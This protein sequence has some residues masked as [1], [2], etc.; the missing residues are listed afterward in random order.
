MRW[1]V[2]KFLVL[3]RLSVKLAVF[4]LAIK[5]KYVLTK[6][7][8]FCISVIILV[9]TGELTRHMLIE[10]HELGMGNGDYAF[11]GVELIKQSGSAG[12]FSWYKPGDRRNKV[13]REMYESLMM[14]AVRVPT[15]PEYTSFVHKVTKISSEEF[16]G[17]ANHENASGPVARIHLPDD[18]NKSAILFAGQSDC[19]CLLR[20]CHDV[21]TCLQLHSCCGWRCPWRSLHGAPSLEHVLS[22]W[23]YN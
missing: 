9:T 16:G 14:L 3:H 4:S 10:A 5:F 1:D 12:D 19:G 11:F 22:K 2:D 17:I 15:S 20:L 18:S 13:A 21:R 7:V 6:P 23:Y 8:F